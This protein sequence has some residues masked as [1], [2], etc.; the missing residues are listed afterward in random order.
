MSS[1]FFLQ[2]ALHN[3]QLILQNLIFGQH[4]LDFVG[5]F[6]NNLLEIP[7][8]SL[9][10]FLNFDDICISLGKFQFESINGLFR[11]QQLRFQKGVLFQKFLVESVVFL[12]DSFIVGGKLFLGDFS[13]GVEGAAGGGVVLVRSSLGR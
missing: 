6:P 5:H 10:G 8:I 3:D 9:T 4:N 12:F 13:S 1:H 7:E 2:S 11:L